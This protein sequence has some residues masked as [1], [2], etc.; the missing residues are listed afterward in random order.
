MKRKTNLR[1]AFLTISVVVLASFA[2]ADAAAL[3]LTE[4]ENQ[5]LLPSESLA[6]GVGGD[7]PVLGLNGV[8]SGEW[9]TA[10]APSDGRARAGNLLLLTLLI[11]TAAATSEILSGELERWRMTRS[12]H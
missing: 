11:I 12:G 1:K 9:V 4:S 8:Q 5:E 7:H 2:R 10:S 3:A 6:A